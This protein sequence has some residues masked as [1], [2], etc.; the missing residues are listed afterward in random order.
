[1]EFRAEL[2]WRAL[3]ILVISGSL[4]SSASVL[5]DAIQRWNSRMDWLRALGLGELERTR[6]LIFLGQVIVDET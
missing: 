3:G 6:G 5:S 1:M 2:L 4:L